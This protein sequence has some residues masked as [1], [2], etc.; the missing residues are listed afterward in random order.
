MAEFTHA[1]VHK[2]RRH[3]LSRSS[4]R[5]M[6][7]A[8][9]WTIYGDPST[10]KFGSNPDISTATVPEDIWTEGGVA[11]FPTEALPVTIA[12]ASGNDVYPSGTGVREITVSGLDESWKYVTA[13]VRMEGASVV[14][15]DTLFIRVFRASVHTVGSLGVPDGKVTIQHGGTTIAAILAGET[16]TEMCTFTVPDDMFGEILSAGAS[17][18]GNNSARIKVELQTRHNHLDAD[19]LGQTAW[20]TRGIAEI[21]GSIGGAEKDFKVPPFLEPKTD[22]RLRVV[23][24]SA[25]NLSITGSFEVICYNPI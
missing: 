22:I 21:R 10:Y 24:A 4:Y 11:F 19:H 6:V 23:E 3:Q 9:F 8:P 5:A 25:N 13:Y 7:P 2:Q 16:S 12:S 15:T 17:I 20:I 1:S 18:E 14:T